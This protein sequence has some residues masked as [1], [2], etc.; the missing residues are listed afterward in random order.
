MHACKDLDYLAL[1]GNTPGG[2]EYRTMRHR[3]ESPMR[4]RASL[5]CPS[6]L[7]MPPKIAVTSC[8]E[9]PFSSRSR[10]SRYFADFPPPNGAPFAENAGR[11][12][13]DASTVSR[14]IPCMLLSDLYFGATKTGQLGVGS[15]PIS[16]CRLCA[17]G[18]DGNDEMS[19]LLISPARS[20]PENCSS[21]SSSLGGCSS[22]RRDRPT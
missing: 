14:I 1:L 16:I 4:T 5:L 19:S 20:S 8:G 2:L 21:L 12:A 22:S 11:V 15:A 6:F 10:L 9:S 17:M 7:V 3:P 13:L 18:D